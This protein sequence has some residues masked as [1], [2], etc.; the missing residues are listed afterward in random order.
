MS[1][2]DGQFYSEHS[3]SRR[4]EG[5]V[6]A[7]RA[8]MVLFYLAAAVGYFLFCYISRFIPLFA[9]CPILIWILVFFTW[10][11]VGY[12]VYCELS[13]GELSVGRERRGRSGK[14]R[15]QILSVHV[16]DA[17]DILPVAPGRV[18]LNGVDVLVDL[19]SSSKREGRVAVLFATK[20]GT[21]AVVID[22]TG[23]LVRL[24]MTYY[25]RTDELKMLLNS[26]E[27]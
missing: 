21:T 20:G 19:S 24:L 17:I 3:Y 7:A 8:L 22:A 10:G 6:L 2:L 18:K 1:D 16:R 23:H 25:H 13:R 12:D 27:K 26:L 9:L 14:K 15:K 4:A 5:R 11:L